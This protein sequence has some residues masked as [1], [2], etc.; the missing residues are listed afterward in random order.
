MLPSGGSTWWAATSGAPPRSTAGP[1]WLTRAPPFSSARWARTE[2][3][4]R[5]SLLS[6]CDASASGA[7]RWFELVTGRGF[8][9][10]QIAHEIVPAAAHHVS[11]IAEAVI[12]VGQQ[13]Q[14]EILVRLDQ[15]VDHQQRIVGRHVAVHGA[16][17]Q[18]QVALQIPG[19][20]LVGLIVVA[21]GAVGIGLE[22][23]LPFLGPIVLIF[24]IVVVARLGDPHFE[25]IGVVEHG[26]GSGIA[27]SEEHTSE[28]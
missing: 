1:S 2:L 28:L 19:R 27:R 23:A 24:A 25:K 8:G 21:G 22:Q 15:L 18:Q 13:Q 10:Q 7:G 17:G 20:Q 5:P 9:A 3:A 26:A 12:A 14:I 16:V 4:A 6:R 11:L